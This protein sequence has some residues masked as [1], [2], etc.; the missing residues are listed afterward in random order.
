M[1]THKNFVGDVADR[2][3]GIYMSLSAD[4]FVSVGKIFVTPICR[5]DFVADKSSSVNSALN[6]L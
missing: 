1:S 4:V 5:S 3:I 6:V 2:Q